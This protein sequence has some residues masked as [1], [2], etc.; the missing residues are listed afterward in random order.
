MAT[1]SQIQASLRNVTDD[2]VGARQ[3]F[4][5]G[6]SIIGQADAV[7]G[8]LGT[9]YGGIITAIDD[10]V[11]ANPSNVMW[12]ELAARKAA[13]IAESVALKAETAAAVAALA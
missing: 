6:K 8:N 5:R 9:T 2:I 13:L 3:Q 4:D 1:V 12:Q 7:M 11:A 10:G